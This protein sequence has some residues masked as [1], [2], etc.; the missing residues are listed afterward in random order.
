MCLS[1]DVLKIAP[2]LIDI[3]GSSDP[4][5]TRVEIELD[6]TVRHKV[7]RLSNPIGYM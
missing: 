6:I 2:Q 4:I 3:C 1:A 5:L 7:G